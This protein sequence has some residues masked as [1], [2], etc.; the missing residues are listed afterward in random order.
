MKLIPSPQRKNLYNRVRLRNIILG[1]CLKETVTLKLRLKGQV[2]LPGT[3]VGRK[4]FQKIQHMQGLLGKRW[5]VQDRVD[6]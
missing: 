4:A 3:R 5:Q 1:K 6:F 2:S